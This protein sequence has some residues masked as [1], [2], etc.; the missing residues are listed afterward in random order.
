M[1]GN[2]V[3]CPS[4]FLPSSFDANFK[5]SQTHFLNKNC[6]GKIR[7]IYKKSLVNPWAKYQW[8]KKGWT[9]KRRRR[10]SKISNLKFWKDIFYKKRAEEKRKIQLYSLTGLHRTYSLC[11]STAIMSIKTM[12]D[13]MSKWDFGRQSGSIIFGRGSHFGFI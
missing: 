10:G 6:T 12:G 9:H 1:H 8:N 7:G 5:V 13:C 3:R 4:I 11:S 2:I